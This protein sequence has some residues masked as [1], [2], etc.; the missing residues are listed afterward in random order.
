MRTSKVFL[1]LAFFNLTVSCGLL[2]N[3]TQKTSKDSHE[4]TSETDL[5]NAAGQ[6]KNQQSH[7]L[8]LYSDSSNHGYQV[9]LWPKGQFKYS[10]TAGFEGEAEKVLITGNLQGIKKG[11]KSAGSSTQES[12]RSITKVKTKAKGKAV[13]TAAEKKSAPSVWWVFGSL[14]LLCIVM[15][16]YL[17]T[18]C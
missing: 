10:A 14:A 18:K 16:Y 12:A 4:F 3:T 9:Q 2:Q 8:N 6:H 1:A 15:I 13:Q 7:S 5:W 17:K 11:A